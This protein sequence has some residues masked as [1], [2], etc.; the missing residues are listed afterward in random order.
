MD[1]SLVD[2]AAQTKP[3]P[4]I[5]HMVWVGSEPPQWVRDRWELWR[6]RAAEDGFELW[7]WDNTAV[8][9][10]LPE[11]HALRALCP[12]PAV[13]ADFVRLE[14]LLLFGGVY[15]DCDMV[16][17]RSMAELFGCPGWVAPFPP[18]KYS[19]SGKLTNAAMG[20]AP[21]HPFAYRAWVESVKR[22]RTAGSRS[23]LS[24]H[25]IAGP[26]V[27]DEL[28]KR[29]PVRRVDG[30]L[31]YPDRRRERLMG[32]TVE[33]MRAAYPEAVAVHEYRMSWREDLRWE[34]G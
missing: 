17:L 15:V 25:H 33:Q 7:L 34:K 28:D 23:H 13:W 14:A 16:P 22:L 20:F 10:R 8:A 21:G 9:E 12:H 5:L 26:P 24:Y 1:E 29:M 30:R 27:F 2:P 4:R 19:N 3:V 6:G 32:M 18:G 31:F 11:S